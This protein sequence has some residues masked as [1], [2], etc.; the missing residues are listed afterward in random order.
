MVDPS[1]LPP[2][3]HYLCVLCCPYMY[4]CFPR[5]DC[6]RLVSG[7]GISRVGQWFH[8]TPLPLVVVCFSYCLCTPPPPPPPLHLQVLRAS[9][10]E[11]LCR[12]TP[13][14]G[15]LFSSEL[16]TVSRNGRLVLTFTKDDPSVEERYVYLTYSTFPHLGH[17]HLE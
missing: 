15:R 1:P 8:L 7:R 6:A 5:R 4:N 16:L 17:N 13:G 9:S 3:P 12:F 10:F 14:V 2:H 11:E